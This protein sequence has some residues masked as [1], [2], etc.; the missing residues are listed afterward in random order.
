MGCVFGVGCAM[1]CNYEL[2]MRRI[3]SFAPLILFLAAPLFA[4]APEPAN[5]NPVP[6]ADSEDPNAKPSE[7]AMATSPRREGFP[8]PSSSKVSYSSCNV[9]QPYIALTFD[10][11]PHAQNT[12]RLLDLLKERKIRATFFLIGQNALEYPDI[13]KRIVAEGHEVANHSFTHPNLVSFSE[14][15]LREQLEKTHQA[16]LKASG[17]SMRLMRPPYGSLSETQRRWVNANFGY[18]VILWDVDPLDWKFRDSERVQN[19]ILSKTHAGSIILT[20]DIHKTTVDAM[21]A[22]L[23]ALR[24]KGFKFVTVSELLSMDK[25]GAPKET[26]TTSVETKSE[27]KEKEKERDS[28]SASN[29]GARPKTASVSEKSKPAEKASD[30]KEVAEAKKTAP[31]KKGETQE[32]LKQKWLRLFGR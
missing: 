5:T 11:G 32:D 25:P 9:E 14:V 24:E 29:A 21:P 12:P 23:D 10:D 15:N 31:A 27:K 16:V 3:F 6:V 22:T 18:R 20:H 30:S 13:V 8:A 17:V 2:R 28:E 26:K 19:E 7:I 4:Q 1:M